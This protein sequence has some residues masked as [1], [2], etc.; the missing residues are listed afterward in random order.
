V[1]W[2]GEFGGKRWWSLEIDSYWISLQG[3][4]RP[5]KVPVM[6]SGTSEWRIYH[7]DI[8][9]S[10]L[11]SVD[12]DL[13]DCTESDLRRNTKK[14]D[15]LDL[16][17]RYRFRFVFWRCSVWTPIWDVIYNDSFSQTLQTNTG[18]IHRI[19]QDH[20]LSNSFE[21][22]HSSIILQFDSEILAAKRVKKGKVVSGLN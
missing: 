8:D 9:I 3:M 11:R 21:I 12:N 10:F 15:A 5:R 6:I 13:P 7:E 18:I 14:R 20:F 22:R 2:T 4:K 1:R 16:V 17:Q 19:D